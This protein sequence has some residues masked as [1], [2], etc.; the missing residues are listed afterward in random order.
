MSTPLVVGLAALPWVLLPAVLLWRLRDSTEIEV[1][2]GPVPEPAPLISVIVPARNEARNIEACMRS[3]LASR[4][5]ALELIVVND[6]STDGTGEIARRLAASDARV[7]VLDAP[8]LPVG[9]FGKQWACHNGVGAARGPL[10][11]FTDAD[12]RHG[13]ELY[14]LAVHAMNARGADLLSVAGDQKMETFWER[15]LQPHIFI[16]IFATFGGTDTTSRATNP[17]SKIANGQ[18]MLMRRHAYERSGGHEAV[19]THVAEDLR[20]AQEFCRHGFSVQI[21]MAMEHLSTRMYEG[22]GEIVR[23]WGKNVFAAGRDVLPLGPAGQLILRLV[24]PFPALWEIV[25]AA[26]AVAG[27]LGVVAPAVGTWG[28]VVYGVTVLYWAAIHHRMKAP[29]AYALLYPMAALMIFGIFTRAAWKGSQVEWKGRHY[30][31]R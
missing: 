31:S 1:Y 23:G 22:L 18:W 4:W 5:P 16:L 9:W 21:V 24:F 20:L 29:V 12:T 6:H 27:A 14:N 13:P 7:R 8:D 19:R 17:K 10:L 11:L 3:I 30:E 15:L 26:V 2:A 25:P 28:A